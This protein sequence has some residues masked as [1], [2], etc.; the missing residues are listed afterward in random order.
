MVKLHQQRENNLSLTDLDPP[1]VDEDGYFKEKYMDRVVRLLGLGFD[2]SDVFRDIYKHYVRWHEHNLSSREI[3]KSRQDLAD[4][5][6]SV[7]QIN[8]MATG[9]VPAEF[10]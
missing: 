9:E 8:V 7:D 1:K 6:A 2:P 10:K 3:T 5:I 4:Y